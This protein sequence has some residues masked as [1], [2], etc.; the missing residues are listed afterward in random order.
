MTIT[1][2]QS[3]DVKAWKKEGNIPDFKG[4]F[5]NNSLSKFQSMKEAMSTK[6]FGPLIHF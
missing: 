4:D 6:T 3:P 1:F 5:N 2:L